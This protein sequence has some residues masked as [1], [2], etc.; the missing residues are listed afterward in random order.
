MDKK[1]PNDSTKPKE[2]VKSKYVARTPMEQQRI[3][4]ERLM[5]NPVNSSHYIK[6]IRN[7]NHITLPCLSPGQTSRYTNK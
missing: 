1:E 3:K 4:V 5:E 7:Q 6:L 2:K